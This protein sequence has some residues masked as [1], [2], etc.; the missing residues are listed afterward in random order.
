MNR[1]PKTA[2]LTLC[3]ILP[4]AVAAKG[5]DTP[6]PTTKP[7]AVVVEAT[8][9]A[10]TVAKG[11]QVV[12]DFLIKNEGQ[13]TLEIQRVEP[14]CGCTVAQFDKSVAPGQ[15]GKV[16]AVVETTTFNGPISKGI[17]VYTNDTDNPRIQLT[18]QAKIEPYIQVKPGYARY[19]TVQGEA[20]AGVIVQSLW[21]PDGSDFAVE[22]VVSPFPYLKAT[23]H[24]ASETERLPDAKGKQWQV[25]MTLD[26]FAA[27]VGSLADYL[28]VHTNHPKQKLVQ[29]PISGFV[30]PVLAVTPP[31]GD[32]GKVTLKE[33]L[34][35][36][37]NV[38]N[39][40]TEDIKLTSIDNPMSGQGLET[41]FDAVQEGREYMVRLT[42][43]PDARKGP[44]AAN[45][46]FHTD[47]QKVPKVEVMIT[48]EVQ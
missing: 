4:L 27:P 25:E 23:F 40:A 24:Q 12:H 20:K 33:K 2:I 45:L 13:A 35:K 5:D 22:D 44:F 48:G 30:R 7:K 34:T 14:G 41:A 43:S 6:V 8:F 47:S 36:T 19:L 28:T 32:F 10:G 15:T 46:V 18:I 1:C 9:D 16:H 21:A 29:I 11:E 17:S 39:F 31:S 38:R 26:N 3:L 37:L 42:L